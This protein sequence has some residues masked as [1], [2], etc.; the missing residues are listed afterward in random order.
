[1]RILHILVQ[2]LE[3]PSIAHDG[4]HAR[5]AQ[6]LEVRVHVVKRVTGVVP[7]DGGGDE[8]L[9]DLHVAEGVDELEF[10]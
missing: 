10:L 3:L 7:E 2:R 9:G 8:L 4:F 5:E 6:A 1:M